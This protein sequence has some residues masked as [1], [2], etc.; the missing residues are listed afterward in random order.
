MSARSESGRLLRDK[1]EESEGELSREK[2]KEDF[3]RDTPGFSFNIN[4]LV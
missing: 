1:G 2:A 3:R 4:Y